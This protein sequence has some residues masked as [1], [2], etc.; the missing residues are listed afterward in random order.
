MILGLCF[1]VQLNGHTI[2]SF[3]DGYEKYVIQVQ[4]YIKENS[5]QF[6]LL[7]LTQILCYHG[8]EALMYY[9]CFYIWDWI[10]HH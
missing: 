1:E 4:K 6:V 8:F 5:I 2:K 3:H 7:K 10:H 9:F